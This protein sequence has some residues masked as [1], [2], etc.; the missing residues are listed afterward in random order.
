M[1]RKGMMGFQSCNEC[2]CTGSTRRIIN[3]KSQNLTRDLM[4]NIVLCHLSSVMRLRIPIRKEA[5]EC[6]KNV[7]NPSLRYS[8]SNES[9]RKVCNLLIEAL[10]LCTKYEVLHDRSN[11]I[12]VNNLGMELVHRRRYNLKMQSL[13]FV[14]TEMKE[15]GREQET[16]MKASGKTQK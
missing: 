15:F 6:S 1:E 5:P 12:K 9:Q 3:R 16:K 8:N 10:L 2:R 14:I 11:I 4:D 13:G 7:A